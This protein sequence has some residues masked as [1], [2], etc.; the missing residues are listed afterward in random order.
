MSEHTFFITCHF[1]VHPNTAKGTLIIINLPLVRSE[2]AKFR[3]Q[4]SNKY[5]ISE[6]KAAAQG[7]ILQLLNLQIFNN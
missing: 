2:T 6:P 7:L 4:T 1:L 5:T 3:S